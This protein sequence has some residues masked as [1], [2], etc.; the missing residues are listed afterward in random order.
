MNS[1]LTFTLAATFTGG[2]AGT[3]LGFAGSAVPTD[4]RLALATLLAMIGVGI[5][6]ADAVGRSVPLI[7]RNRETPRP[8]MD[9]G[10]LRAAARNGVALGVGA[11]TRI[12][13]WLWYA[14]PVGA[15]LVGDPALGAVIYGSYAVSRAVGLWGLL[16]WERYRSHGPQPR[17]GPLSPSDPAI[18]LLRHGVHARRLAALNLVGLGLT[19][20]VTVGM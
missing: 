17:P 6:A 4:L 3:L 5:G 7:Q 11:T 10:P 15:L 13:V 19:V 18:W 1:A 14:V 12:G 2:V 16:A 20:F 8:W 9:H